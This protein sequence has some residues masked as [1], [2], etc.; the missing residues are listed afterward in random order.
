MYQVL[1]VHGSPVPR[2]R[3]R[4]LFS[5]KVSTPLADRGSHL[6][7]PV[8]RLGRDSTARVQRS[9]ASRLGC[10]VN[11]GTR[12]RGSSAGSDRSLGSGPVGSTGERLTP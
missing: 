7:C 10:P 3:S 8:G 11:P 4:G 1:P 12:T 2:T 6:P 9:I 5:E